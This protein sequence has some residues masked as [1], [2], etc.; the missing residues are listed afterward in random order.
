M[1]YPSGLKAAGKR[2]WDSIQHDFELAEHEVARLEQAC[3]VRDT[4]DSLRRLLDADGL[5]I[6]SSQGA[7]MHPAVAEIRQQQLVL[8]RLLASLGVPPLAED[9][10]P[11]ARAV[12]GVYPVGL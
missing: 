7:R 4:L 2:L 10:L 3:R 9:Q 8:A 6:S 1:K 5:M 11:V 12:R